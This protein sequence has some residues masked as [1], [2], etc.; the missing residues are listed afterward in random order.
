MIKDSIRAKGH[1]NITGRHETTIEITR[2]AEISIRADCII[3]VMADKAVKHISP[4]LKKHL[5]AGG[6]IEAVISVGGSDFSFKAR[7]CPKLIL[8]SDKEIVFRKSTYVDERTIAI[9]ATAAAKDI[10]RPMI[11]MLKKGKDVLLEI[12][13]L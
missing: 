2:D 4:E 9:E 8:S 5:L 3:G 10:P 11:E 6:K 1:P 7:G 12:R 13:A